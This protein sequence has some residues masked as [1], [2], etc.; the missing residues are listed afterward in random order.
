GA[1][2]FNTWFT[3]V[4][5][6]D[7]G[8]EGSA[9]HASLTLQNDL[10]GA[11]FSFTS[12]DE[13]YRPA[14]GFVR[15]RD[16][17]EYEVEA[18]YTPV[19]ESE[20]LPWLRR[21]NVFS[22]YEYIEGQDGEKQSTELSALLFA[23][24]SRRDNIDLFF[25]RNFERLEVPFFIQADT[26]IPAGDYTFTQ[27]GL[28]GETDSSRRMYG[29]ANLSVGSFFNGN[30]TDIEGSFGFRQSQ[31]L[32][33]EGSI[34]HSIIDLPVA[35][36]EFDATTLSLSV[37]G[38]LNRKFFAKALVQYDNFSRDLQANIRFDWIHTPGSDLFLVFNTSYHFAGDNEIL[39][40][41]RRDVFLNNRVGIAKLTYLIL[42]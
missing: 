7:P 2:E 32:Q 37:L 15:R 24:F 35:N 10:Y 41:P 22:D 12:V 14:L 31:Y 18:Q 6:S 20:A 3:N 40:D 30:R 13:N 26:E 4:Q 33:L 11:G 28:G 42:L 25:E 1:S 21:F 23:Q 9:G 38:A 36:G 17:R 27:V 29:G 16:M 39:F 5:D 19:I 34:S 8:N